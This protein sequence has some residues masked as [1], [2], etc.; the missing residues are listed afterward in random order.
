MLEQGTQLVICWN[1]YQNIYH[2]YHQTPQVLMELSKNRAINSYDYLFVSILLHVENTLF[3]KGQW[4]G[5][6][7]K[8]ILEMCGLLTGNKIVESRRRA[9]ERRL[10]G[11]RLGYRGHAT[12]YKI[13]IPREWIDVRSQAV[14]L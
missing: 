9:I 10:I 4:F 14:A 1:E 12:E 3:K 2:K 6:S 13:L 7:D 8:D 5:Y 11:C